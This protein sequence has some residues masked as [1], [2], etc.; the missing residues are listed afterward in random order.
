MF[1][2]SLCLNPGQCCGIFSTCSFK[3]LLNSNVAFVKK[4]PGTNSALATCLTRPCLLPVIVLLGVQFPLP[5]LE[6]ILELSK[7]HGFILEIHTCVGWENTWFCGGHIST[8]NSLKFRF[9]MQNIIA[10]STIIDARL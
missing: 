4:L 6:N 9:P 1:Y 7:R 8:A 5:S 10:S 3:K 2:Q